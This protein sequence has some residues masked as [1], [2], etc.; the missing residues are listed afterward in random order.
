MWIYT[1]MV[2]VFL[3]AR[4]TPLRLSSIRV[5]LAADPKE[6]LPVCWDILS[7]LNLRQR[8]PTIVACPTCGRSC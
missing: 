7:S 3:R 4:G 2:L 5:S 8:G 6:E 1:A